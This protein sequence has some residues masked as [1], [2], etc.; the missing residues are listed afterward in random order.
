MLRVLYVLVICVCMFPTVPGFVGVVAASISYIPPLGLNSPAMIGFSQVFEWQGV[1]YSIF[2]TLFT[3]LFSSYLACFITYSILMQCWQSRWWKRI[4][5]LLSP[6]LAIPH[7]AYAIGFAFL[8]APTGLGVRGIHALFGVDLNDS[9]SQELAMLI[10][11]PYGLGLGI[12]L[13]L[14]EVPFLLLMSIPILKQLN[15]QKIEKVSASLGYSRAQTWWKCVL[16]QWLNKMRFS[17]LAVLAYSLAVVDVSLI[18]GPTNPPTFAVLVWQ[19][20]NDPDL[21]MMPRASAGA[22]ILFFIACIL[23][24]TARLIEWGVTKGLR[25]W[26]C[27]GRFGLKLP[28]AALFSAIAMLSTVML[29]LMA[30]WSVA[31]RWRFPDILPSRFSKQFWEYEWENILGTIE[32]SVSI[33]LTSSTI[34]LVFAMVV[35]ESRIRHRIQV[36]GYIIA[37]P[38]LIPQLSVLFGMQIMTLFVEHELYW[39][40]VCWAHIF[41][42][43]PFVYLSLDGPWRSYNQKHTKVALSLGKSPLEVFFKV[44]LGMLVPA[45]VFAWA[46]G[47][48][49]SLAQ[50]LPTLILGAGRINTL[51]TE[52]VALASGFDQRVTAIYALWQALLPFVFFSIALFVSRAKFIRRNITFKGFKLNGSLLKKSFNI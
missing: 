27:S 4:E 47:I 5:L 33:A 25:G 36:P 13:A 39:F 48:S 49:V 1:E 22:I 43:F 52:A 51:T 45:V 6:M 15:I 31:Q 29:P 7:V 44:K 17:M 8:F 26:Q 38:M 30:V 28:G 9:T 21:S 24:T 16:P 19:W 41:F 3:A 42:A 37:I 20:F 35:H 50:Y 14:K 12:M 11:D 18:L 2:L 32:Q 46:M 34:A 23:I 10:Q 40:W